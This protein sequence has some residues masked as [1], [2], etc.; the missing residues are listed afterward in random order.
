MSYSIDTM[1]SKKKYAIYT[2]TYD[3]DGKFQFIIPKLKMDEREQDAIN[4]TNIISLEMEIT[5]SINFID[6]LEKK[7]SILEE[8]LGIENS[9]IPINQKISNLMYE[10]TGQKYKNNR[11]KNNNNRYKNNNRSKNNNNRSKNNKSKKNKK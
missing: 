7:V 1:F 5:G 4:L 3:N 2:F 11:S 6:N 10:I 8:I 9:N